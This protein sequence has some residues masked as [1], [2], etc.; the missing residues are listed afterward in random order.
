MSNNYKIVLTRCFLYI[1]IVALMTGCK[2]IATS[3]VIDTITQEEQ[4]ETF[5]GE[6]IQRTYIDEELIEEMSSEE[7]KGKGNNYCIYSKIKTKKEY[8][9]EEIEADR[10]Q[11][12]F[13]LRD[14]KDVINGNLLTAYLP[15]KN[16]Y[17][18][19]NVTLEKKIVEEISRMGI[20]KALETGYLKDYV[21]E[22]ISNIEQDYDLSIEDDIKVNGRLTQHIIATSKDTDRDERAEI[23]IDQSTWLIVKELV[24]QGNILVSF[25]YTSF[26]INPIINDRHFE[27]SIPSTAKVVQLED[28]I[29]EIN[30]VVTIKEARELLG[31]PIYYLEGNDKVKSAEIHYIKDAGTLYGRIEITYV[32]NDG[33]KIVIQTLPNNTINKKV[34]I[35]Y[36]TILIK[37]KEADYIE[38]EGSRIIM[39]NGDQSICNIYTQNSNISKSEFIELMDFLE[40]KS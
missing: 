16:E 9:N 11:D 27:I 3:A 19:K 25:E 18:T 38:T 6:S 5:H 20:C 32:T 34:K 2:D 14:E 12:G 40:I 33:S 15:Y 31:V 39:I 17:Y 4:V 29:E 30:E 8:V 23:W 36:E 26:Q 37:G 22:C 24:V 21:M 35:D 7:W 28:G 10:V 13:I 1:S